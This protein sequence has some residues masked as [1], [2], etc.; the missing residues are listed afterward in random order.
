MY[1]FV[2]PLS[3]PTNTTAV[4]VFAIYSWEISWVD[5]LV[6]IAFIFSNCVVKWLEWPDLAMIWDIFILIRYLL[7]V[8]NSNLI[9]IF[10]L[11]F[12]I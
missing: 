7:F 6:C 12:Y 4:D 3:S 10:Y 8:S 5:L 11:Y 9:F 1:S 2:S